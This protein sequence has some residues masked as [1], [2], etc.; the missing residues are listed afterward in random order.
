MIK[1]D[2]K[3]ASCCKSFICNS[4]V[5]PFDSSNSF[6]EV[7]LEIL[8]QQISTGGTRPP[9]AMSQPELP[10]LIGKLHDKTDKNQIGEIKDH[11]S[12]LRLFEATFPTE[13]TVKKNQVKLKRYF[14]GVVFEVIKVGICS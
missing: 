14:F 5:L 13:W 7:F 10:R 12:N 4:P 6:K 11:I 2:L 9:V 3:Q 1:G 8:L